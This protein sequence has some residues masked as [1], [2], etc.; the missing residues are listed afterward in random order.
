MGEFTDRL[1]ILIIA[2]VGLGSLI[3]AWLGGFVVAEMGGWM[4]I[5]GL[6]VLVVLF[7]VALVGVWHEFNTVE[8]ESR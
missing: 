8:T 7:L 5:G 1:L 2:V 6:A 4:E 3:I